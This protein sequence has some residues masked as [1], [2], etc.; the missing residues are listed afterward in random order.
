[1]SI[2]PRTATGLALLLLGSK[3][4]AFDWFVSLP[5]ANVWLVNVVAVQS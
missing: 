5:V 4:V 2:L 1:M 3:D